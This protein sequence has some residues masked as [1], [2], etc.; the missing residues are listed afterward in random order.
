[1]FYKQFQVSIHQKR[2]GALQFQISSFRFLD[3]YDVRQ[4]R[5]HI[6]RL[7]EI[8]T[9]SRRP[10]LPAFCREAK[11]NKN[12]LAAERAASIEKTQSNNS[13]EVSKSEKKTP[14][15]LLEAQEKAKQ[16]LHE[17]RERATA[18]GMSMPSIKGAVSNN[19]GLGD[20]YSP[21][22]GC[23]QD[24]TKIK[25]TLEKDAKDRMEKYVR[26][27]ETEKTRLQE[28]HA[29]LVKREQD[30][31]TALSLETKRISNLLYINR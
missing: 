19:I 5:L 18:L 7:R 1:M 13:A 28:S 11:K 9:T 23:H 21:A 2:N 8:L 24:E 22:G 15:S 10:L 20:F 26:Q 31:V 3:N 4:A 27:T 14:E 17:E 29:L 6:R 16:I 12:R 30:A 25:V